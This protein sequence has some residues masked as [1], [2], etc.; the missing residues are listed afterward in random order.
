MHKNCDKIVYLGIEKYSE[1]LNFLAQSLVF[2][3]PVLDAISQLEQFGSSIGPV[4]FFRHPSKD[5]QMS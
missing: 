2:K 1:D 4:F 3:C 5:G